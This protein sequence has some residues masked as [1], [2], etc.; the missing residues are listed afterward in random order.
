LEFN[1][2]K[3]LKDRKTPISNS[4]KFEITC[5]MF[6]KSITSYFLHVVTVYNVY[7]VTKLNK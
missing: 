3:V 5:A 4:V 6:E 2:K 7:I 1:E